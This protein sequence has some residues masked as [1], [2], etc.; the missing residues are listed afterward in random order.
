[1]RRKFLPRKR[2]TGDGFAVSQRA[3]SGRHLEIAQP[4]MAGTNGNVKKI[5]SGMAEWFFRPGRDSGGLRA[6]TQR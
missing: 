6:K 1:M 3:A 5:P 2:S 4:F